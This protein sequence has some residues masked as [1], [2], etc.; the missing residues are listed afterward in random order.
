MLEGI[1]PGRRAS[2][3][4]ALED[5]KDHHKKDSHNRIWSWI[6]I[7]DLADVETKGNIGKEA[8]V[9]GVSGCIYQRIP[10]TRPRGSRADQVDEYCCISKDFQNNGEG[11]AV[12]AE[13]CVNIV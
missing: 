3:T 13:R 12:G 6:H 7:M 2:S 9:L 8:K 10:T 5:M 4:K 11:P 1:I